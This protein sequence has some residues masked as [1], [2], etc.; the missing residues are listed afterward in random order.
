[1]KKLIAISL[2]LIILLSCLPVMAFASDAKVV[3]GAN[4]MFVCSGA[5]TLEINGTSIAAPEDIEFAVDITVSDNSS[6]FTLVTLNGEHLSKIVDGSNIIKLK[7]SMLKEGENELRLFLGTD[8]YTYTDEVVYGSCNADDLTVES[9]KFSGVD[10]ASPKSA[11][12]YMPI[13]GDLG[14]TVTDTEYK[15]GI[16]VG[17]GWFQET[18]LGGNR[19]DAPVSVGYLFDRPNTD[20]VFYVDTTKIPDGAHTVKYLKNGSVISTEDIVVDNTAPVISFSVTNGSVIAKNQTCDVNISD[21]TATDTTILV[22]GKI[23]DRIEPSELDVGS[24]TAFVTSTDSAG[25]SASKMLI[26]EVSENAYAV[27][28][29]DDEVK[30]SANSEASVYSGQLLTNIKMFENRYGVVNQ[31]YLR[32]SDEVLVSFNDKANTVTKAIG[33]SV[34]Y[35]SFVFET[36]GDKE[37]YAVVSYTGETGNGSGILLKAWNYKESKWDSI[38]TTP[39]GVPVSIKVDLATYSYKSKMRINALPNIVYNGS[40]TILWNSDTQFYARFEDLNDTYYKINEYAVEQYNAGKIGYCLHTGDLMDQVYISDEVTHT[41]YGVADKAQAILDDAGVPNG[42]VSGNHD[43]NHDLAD[44]QYYWQ[45]FGEDRYKDFDWY[46]GSLNNNM[47]HYDLVSIGAHDFVFLYIGTYKENDPDL[48]AWAN[49]VCE[50]YPNRNVIL[51]THEYLLASGEY[52]G[53]RAE[54]I[55]NEIVVPNENVVM[56][57]CG[58]NEGVCDQLKQVGNTDRYVL[59]ILADYQFC[60]LGVGPQH[61][62]NGITCDGEGFVRLMTFNDAGQLISST[63]S[64][65]AEAHGKDPYNFFPSYKDSFVYDMK[66]VESNRSIKTTDFNVVVSPELVGTTNGNSV[67][68]DGCDAVYTEYTENG[69]TVLS[70]IFVLDEYEVDYDV[71]EHQYETPVFDKVSITGLEN[72]SENFRMDTDNTVPTGAWLNKGINLLPENESNLKYASGSKDYTFAKNDKGGYTVNHTFNGNHWLTLQ[73]TISQDVDFSEYDRIYFGVTADKETKWNICINFFGKVINFSQDAAIAAQFGYVNQ[74]PS[75]ITGTW[76][77]YIELKDDQPGYMLNNI[78]LTC[79]TPGAE[80]TFDYLFLG[81]STGGKVRFI[82]TD[83][84]VTTVDAVIG[85]SVALPNTPFKQG[86]TFDGW[87]T[88][89][90]GGEKLDGTVVASGELTEVYAHF[91]EKTVSTRTIETFNNEINLEQF[92]AGKLIFVIACLLFMVAVVVIMMV[93]IKKSKN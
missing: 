82:T 14:M 51:C 61:V 76:C 49:S 55:W 48:I 90:E 63:Y 12:L 29:T 60:E 56:V 38:G 25:N 71:D 59:E 15:D 27:E 72:V 74:K 35:Q 87:Y 32:S 54:V 41:E 78:Q 23:V 53:N 88:A 7:V 40:D 46:G 69:K 10:F 11:K 84:I 39:S 92:S 21:T 3:N 64:P 73:N 2:T 81:K 66:L 79:A 31:D 47:H 91:S 8:F 44:Y 4:A 58:H 80:V 36:N 83:K 42:V 86:Y 43:I 93:K 19:L 6:A 30:M 22:D 89:K 65:T 26:F 85:E 24:H 5:D 16:F 37:G 70:K 57:L 50:M 75:D 17:D 52:S 18:G 9:V 13:E 67:D 28:I 1:M 20:G 77:G 33:N 68:V 34:P 45:Y 62:L